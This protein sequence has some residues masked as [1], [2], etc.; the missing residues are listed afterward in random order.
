MI[1]DT[2]AVSAVL[3]ATTIRDIAGVCGPYHLPAIVIGEY[4]FGLLSS[5]ENVG[6]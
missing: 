5:G 1:L 6:D 4:L 2:N 3:A